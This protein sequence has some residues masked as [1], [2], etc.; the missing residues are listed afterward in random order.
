MYKVAFST[1]G[2]TI[3]VDAATTAPLGLLATSLGTTEATQ[4]RIHNSGNVVIFYAYGSTG[5]EAQSRAVIP[6]GSG[7][8]AQYCSPLPPGAAEIV[9]AL[10]NCY[11]SAVTASGSA[12]VYITP[13]RGL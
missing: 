12:E 3:N 5:A 1:M 9:S 7:S 13:G 6:T 10:P 2:P 11:W 8:D 4:Y